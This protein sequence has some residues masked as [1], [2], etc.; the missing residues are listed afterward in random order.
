MQGSDT[1]TVQARVFGKTLS[2]M[3]NQIIAFALDEI[4]L[5]WQIN[6]G[7]PLETKYRT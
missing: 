2:T 1:F 4:R 7:T 5:T 3:T 6:S